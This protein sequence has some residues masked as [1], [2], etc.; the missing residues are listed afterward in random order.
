MEWQAVSPALWDLLLIAYG[1]AVC[2]A[3]PLYLLAILQWQERS[4]QFT[5]AMF[6]VVVCFI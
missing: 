1:R 3:P 5:E 2:H 4:F 6:F